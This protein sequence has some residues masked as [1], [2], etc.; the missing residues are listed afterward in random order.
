MH[1]L[2]AG[3]DDPEHQAATATAAP[4][5]PQVP[6]APANLAPP[7]LV[8]SL[9]EILATQPAALGQP[10]DTVTPGTITVQSLT[11][12]GAGTTQ[13]AATAGAAP[14][15]TPVTLPQAMHLAA[16]GAPSAPTPL[17]AA[18]PAAFLAPDL[19]VVPA[20]GTTLL[21]GAAVAAGGAQ[22]VPAPAAPAAAIAQ[23]QQPAAQ[24]TT[25]AAAATRTP[26]SGGWC[27]A[28]RP[29]EDGGEGAC[30]CVC[31][32]MPHGGAHVRRCCSQEDKARLVAAA[33]KAFE[34]TTDISRRL[35]TGY[36]K[37]GLSSFVAASCVTLNYRR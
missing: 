9:Q 1:V 18:V 10:T 3:K 33:M 13:A 35:K 14:S 21:P 2:A 22:P 32:D 29:A 5:A 12:A 15:T 16:A 6:G 11:T 34:T 26:C 23:Q 7:S 36:E 28:G 19:A 30:A 4:A 20:Q 8:A 24:A 37:V 27:P 31:T 25:P 17:P